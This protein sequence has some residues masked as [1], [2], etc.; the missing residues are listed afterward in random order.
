[1]H[2]RA[3]ASGGQRSTVTDTPPAPF[4]LVFEMHFIIVPE[5]THKA[6]L[7]VSSRDPVLYR[8]SSPAMGVTFE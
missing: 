1:M 2:I 7:T 4:A 5:L 8:A 6:R 3:N